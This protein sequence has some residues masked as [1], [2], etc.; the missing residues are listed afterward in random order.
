VDLVTTAFANS[1]V[2]NPDGTTGIRMHHDFGQGGLFT[3]GNLIA[4]ADGVI[5]GGVNNTD[6]Q[7][8]KN[9]NFASNR[10]GYFH[11]V[12]LPHRYNTNSGSSGQAELPGNDL[13]VSLYCFGSTDNV[14]H[15]IMHELGHNLNLQHGGFESCNWKP[16]YNSVMNYK[17][18]FPGA[19]NNCTPP[20]DGVLD[21]SRGTRIALNENAL[22]ENLGICGSPSWDWNGNSV[23]ENPVVFD[24]NRDDNGV[25]D[26]TSCAAALTTLQDSNDWANVIFTGL[27]DVDGA[28]VR[29][30]VVDCNPNPPPV[31][32]DEP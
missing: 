32:R 9:A 11:Y 23:I 19:D 21:Y 14:A 27:S 10:R 20:G 5:A 12:L 17:Y 28:P 3:G 16:N 1:T 31:F 30:P 29:R 7:S 15:T 13:I 2:T 4:D 22:N 18:Q 24:L 6:F 8:Y 26:N 25:V